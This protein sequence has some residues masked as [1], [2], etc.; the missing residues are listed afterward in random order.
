MSLR[1]LLVGSDNPWRMEAAVE[2]AMKRL[3]HTTLLIDDRRMKRKI[4]RTLTQRWAK[5]HAKR[6][7][8]DF[9]FL[10]KCL[11]LDPETVLAIVND[12]PNAMWYHDPQ[13]YRDLDRPD[14]AHIATIGRLAR[15][16]FVTGFE[17]E[18]RAHGLNAL[19]LPAAGDAG[20]RP[21]PPTRDSHRTSPSWERVT[22]PTAR[23][24]S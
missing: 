23:S 17:A 20:I 16:F 18:W 4:G 21:V 24:R 12:T 5:W 14:I 1:I 15:T 13:W 7:Q 10:S 19:F 9:V 6:F 2:R 11:A 22:M 3:G 8:P